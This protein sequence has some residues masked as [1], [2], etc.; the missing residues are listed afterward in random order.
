MLPEI[1]NPYIV[2]NFG[3]FREFIG[4]S[5]LYY[6]KIIQDPAITLDLLP[7]YQQARDPPM[8]KLVMNQLV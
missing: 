8:Q 1:L 6:S 3:E 2:I 7:N 4:G 5:I